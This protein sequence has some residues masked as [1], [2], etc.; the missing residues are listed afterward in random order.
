MNPRESAPDLE[1]LIVWHRLLPPTRPE[2]D[3]PRLAAEWVTSVRTRGEGAKGLPLAQVGG[4]V[5]F[6]FEL[7]DIEVAL[8]FCLA[9]L[10]ESE[11][12]G[13]TIGGPRVALGL[14][15]G[16]FET[17]TGWYGGSAIDRAQLL[18]A[19]A[20]R[21]E[22]VLDEATRDAVEHRYLFGRTI[23]SCLASVRGFAVDRSVPRRQ[24]CRGWISELKAAPV[25]A[26]TAAALEEVRRLVMQPR[27]SDCIVLRGSNANGSGAFI[28][29]L[30][31][32]LAPSVTL[33]FAGVPGGLEPLGSLRLALSREWGSGPRLEAALGPGSSA[34]G[35]VAR[36]M[37]VEK[38]V[39]FEELSA[40]IGKLAAN[41]R[42]WFVFDLSL[43]HI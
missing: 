3:N 22:L 18:A 2:E 31:E 14:A 6:A 17:H 28:D 13:A 37:P 42:P 10:D 29:G 15:I 5:A 35:R 34:L 39:L 21:G 43:I 24:A 12:R 36:G 33:H 16:T 30:A 25:P 40:L 27:G 9:L 11:E 4:A 38:M 23:G 1:R 26:G 7:A 20:R 19:R 8:E 41:G 32:E